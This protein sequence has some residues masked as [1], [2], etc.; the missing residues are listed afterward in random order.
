M[1]RF[2]ALWLRGVCWCVGAMAAVVILGWVA[3]VAAEAP[4]PQ[5]VHKVAFR[6]AFTTTSATMAPLWAAEEGG[7]FDEEG[8]QVTLTLI[9]T[10]GSSGNDRAALLPER[11]S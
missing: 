5:P 4:P 2:M 3:W 8:L 10:G 6:S 1:T 11:R 9:F 7:F